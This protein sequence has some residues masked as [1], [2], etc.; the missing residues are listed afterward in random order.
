MTGG[1]EK[2]ENA[3]DSFQRPVELGG[4]EE[5]ISMPERFANVEGVDT[6]W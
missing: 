3:I 1:L 5:P 2:G 6:A 4:V